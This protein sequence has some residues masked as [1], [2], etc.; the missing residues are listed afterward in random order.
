MTRAIS[1]ILLA[2]TLAACSNGDAVF[3]DNSDKVW[4][5]HRIPSK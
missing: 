1:V 5:N 4:L 2:A 3:Q